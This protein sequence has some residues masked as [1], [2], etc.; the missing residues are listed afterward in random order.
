MPWRFYIYWSSHSAWF[1]LTCCLNLCCCWPLRQESWPLLRAQCLGWEENRKKYLF[2]SQTL[3]L[4]HFC[5]LQPTFTVPIPFSVL[6]WGFV[7][8]LGPG[9]FYFCLKQKSPEG[10][11]KDLVNSLR[12][13]R[14]SHFFWAPTAPG[15]KTNYYHRKF[16]CQK[17]FILFTNK[18][19]KLTIYYNRMTKIRALNGV[20]GLL[21]C[22]TQG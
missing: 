2:P 14:T 6:I 12:G 5:F 21:R 20:A 22:Q 18:K 15:T 17:Y 8:L 9:K 16:S 10:R 11:N 7:C 19:T 3:V 13:G 1:R 4:S